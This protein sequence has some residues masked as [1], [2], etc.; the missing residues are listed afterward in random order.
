MVPPHEQTRRIPQEA[1]NWAKN[2]S[3]RQVI[4]G[5]A[6]LQFQHIKAR[7]DDHGAHDVRA[8]VGVTAASDVSQFYC[9]ADRERATNAARA[10][11]IQRP[12]GAESPNRWPPTF[13]FCIPVPNL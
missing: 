12:T 13:Q 6:L 10:A 3:T 1:Q 11:S 7:L 4:D 2:P 9:M 5:Q 8:E